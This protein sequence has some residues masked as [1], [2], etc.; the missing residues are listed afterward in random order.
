MSHWY[1]PVPT[2]SGFNLCF[3]KKIS[4]TKPSH[5]CEECTRVLRCWVPMHLDRKRNIFQGLQRTD[6]ECL[7]SF[8]SPWSSSSSSSYR[9]KTYQINTNPKKSHLLMSSHLISY[10]FT[11]KFHLPSSRS[12]HFLS[13]LTPASYWHHV[14]ATLDSEMAKYFHNGTL[15][16]WCE[17]EWRVSGDFTWECTCSCIV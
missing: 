5:I 16:R 7:S 1:E 15:V 14:A 10:P 13:C 3:L 9:I 8:S 4:P 12:V 2:L 11:I 6:T 17:S